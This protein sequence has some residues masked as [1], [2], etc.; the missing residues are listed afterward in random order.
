VDEIVAQ[1][2]TTTIKGSYATLAETMQTIK[3]GT[4]TNQVPTFIP[5]CPIQP[6]NRNMLTFIDRKLA[7]ANRELRPKLLRYLKFGGYSGQ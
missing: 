2:K 6:N 4:L 5:N 3:M 7:S 1:D